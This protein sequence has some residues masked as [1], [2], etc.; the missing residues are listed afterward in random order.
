MVEARV[1]ALFSKPVTGGLVP[2]QSLEAVAGEGFR[3]DRTRGSKKRQVLLVS[4]PVLDELGY[5]PGVL[6]EQVTVDDPNLQSLDP[7]AKVQV[8]EVLIEITQDCEPCGKMARNLGENPKEFM[9]KTELRRGMLGR[10]L[11]DG[12]IKI[13]DGFRRVDA[14]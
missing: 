7:G 5:E 10:I 1:V 13:G 8:G 4:K 9:A 2:V 6:R 3:G 11:T 12:V 14:S